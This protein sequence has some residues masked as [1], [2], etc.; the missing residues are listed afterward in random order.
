MKKIYLTD[1][2]RTFLIGEGDRLKFDGFIDTGSHFY[3]KD[4][5]T[6]TFNQTDQP[7]LPFMYKG[8]MHY[9]LLSELS[10]TQ[11]E[12]FRRLAA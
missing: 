7:M 6:L 10:S 8:A 5:V 2:V 12:E 9:I 3:V 11:Q 4:P 1:P